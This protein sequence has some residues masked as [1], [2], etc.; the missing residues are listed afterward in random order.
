[1]K[2]TGKG[3]EDDSRGTLMTQ[4]S[5]GKPHIPGVYMDDLGT[6]NVLTFIVLEFSRRWYGIVRGA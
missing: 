1:M 2:K 5:D 4:E 6:G 3:S